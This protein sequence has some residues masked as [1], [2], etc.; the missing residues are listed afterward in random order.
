MP[1]ADPPTPIQTCLDRLAAGDP[2]A[3][4]D[5]IRVSRGRLLALVRGQL[6]RSPALRRWVE[7]E[8]ALHDGFL[9]LDRAV[10]AAGPATTGHYLAVAATIYRW[11]LRDLIRKHLGAGGAGANLATPGGDDPDPLAGAADPAA[12]PAALA[13][14]HE[15]LARIDRLPPSQR[16]AIDLCYYHGLTQAEIGRRLGVTE[17]TV[18]RLLVEAELRLG[19]PAEEPIPV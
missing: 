2:D 19:Q 4:R 14:L 13:E 3:R 11:T 12:G 5:L 8:D 9:K 1:A 18:R 10:A 15:L 6:A 16:A 7:S 17:R